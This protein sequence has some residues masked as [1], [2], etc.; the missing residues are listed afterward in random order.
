MDELERAARRL[1]ETWSDDSIVGR[2]EHV[3]AVDRRIGELNEVLGPAVPDPGPPRAA[4][5]LRPGGGVELRGID[6]S[7]PVAFDLAE[8]AGEIRVQVSDTHAGYFSRGMPEAV[9]L[10]EQDLGVTKVAAWVP[11]TLNMLEDGEMMRAA[12]D[13]GIDRQL[14]PWRYPDDLKWPSIELFPRTTTAIARARRL[15]DRIREVRYVARHGL[16]EVDDGWDD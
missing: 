4:V 5:E 8:L 11:A 16:P 2:D 7:P 14:R 9:A 12:I 1:V 10:V 6:L 15:R 13:R 3:D